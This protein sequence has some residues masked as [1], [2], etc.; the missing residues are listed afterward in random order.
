MA[1]ME[2][3]GGSGVRLRGGGLVDGQVPDDN[4]VLVGSEGVKDRVAGT[5]D[6]APGAAVRVGRSAADLQEAALWQQQ[7]RAEW[8]FDE[9]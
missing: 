6:P 3:R 7:V 4:V 2:K 5:G 9:S 8:A 1:R